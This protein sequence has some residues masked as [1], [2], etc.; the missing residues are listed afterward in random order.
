MKDSKDS[1]TRFTDEKAE[2]RI[3]EII[4]PRSLNLQV[5]TSDLNSSSFTS[6]YILLTSWCYAS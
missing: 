4:D 1:Y 5:T 2:S 6:N 3:H